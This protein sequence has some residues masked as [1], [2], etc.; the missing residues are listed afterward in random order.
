MFVLQGCPSG[1]YGKDCA[2]LSS[3]SDGG[4]CNPVTGRCN[5]SPG[6]MGQY[7]QQGWN[8]TFPTQLHV[9]FVSFKHIHTRARSD[10][11]VLG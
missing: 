10:Q 8:Q 5:C 3:C 4:Q 9:S 1:F 6:R 11:K 7:C 2:K